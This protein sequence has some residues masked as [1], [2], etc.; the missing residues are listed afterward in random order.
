[1]FI[2]KKNL[3]YCMNRRIYILKALLFNL[4]VRF[5]LKAL[6]SLQILNYFT[7][8]KVSNISRFFFYF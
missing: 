6:K 5:V 7:C 2:K 4:K 8:F 1:M 3:S